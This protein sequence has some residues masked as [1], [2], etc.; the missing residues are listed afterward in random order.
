MLGTVCMKTIPAGTLLGCFGL[1]EPSEEG[2]AMTARKD[3]NSYVLN[4]LK[5]WVTA[6][7]IADLAIVW[8]EVRFLNRCHLSMERTE[9]VFT[10][11]YL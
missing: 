1:T 8:A 11:E 7:P 3:G 5:T 2:F 10:S 9:A 4:G 6:A